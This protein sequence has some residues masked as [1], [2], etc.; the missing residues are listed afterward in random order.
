MVTT[1]RI[2][3]A[4]QANGDGTMNCHGLGTFPC[5]G[6]P[7]L[8]YP[9]DLTVT[10]ADKELLHHSIEFNCDMPYAIRIWGQRGIYIH[11][12][13]YCRASDG[14]SEGCIHLCRPNAATVFNW[15]TG[16]TRIT[17]TYPW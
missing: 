7:G 6:R 2:E 14:P 1:Q 3:I 4:F 9:T 5:E 8:K 13:G 11:E 17:I 10:A 16:P 15:I 12:W